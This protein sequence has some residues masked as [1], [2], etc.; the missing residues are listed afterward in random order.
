V[1]V[2]GEDGRWADMG[3]IL[4]AAPDCW[5]GGHGLYSTPRDYVKFQRL[6][7]AGGTCAGVTILQQATVDAAFSNQIGELD[8]P[9]AIDTA[10]PRS[11]LGF[12]PGPDYKWGYGL[13][14]NT[15]E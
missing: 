4:P 8:F 11:S 2:K 5:T 12:Y 3:E 6:L 7:L 14:L 10:D 13:L 15:A 9:A 1:H